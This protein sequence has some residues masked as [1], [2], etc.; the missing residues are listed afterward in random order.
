MAYISARKCVR[1]FLAAFM[2]IMAA[3]FL[4]SIDGKAA[5]QGDQA[6]S[7]RYGL[8]AESDSM[9]GVTLLANNAWKRVGNAYYNGSGSKINGA[10][11]KGIDVSSNNGSIDWAAVKADGVEFAI[12]RCGYGMNQTDQDDIRWE[13]NV[14][15]C[16]A[17]GMPY[18]V[19][20]YSYADS[21]SKAVSE[22]NHVLRLIKGHNLSLPVY[23]DMED[24]SI[25]NNT[26]AKQRGKIAAAFC[27]KIE[28]AGYD[29]AI[30]ANYNAFTNELPEETF[31]QW[32]RWVARYNSSCGYK[33]TY[34]MWQATNKGTVDGIQGFVD[35]DFRISSQIFVKPTIKVATSGKK[36]AKITWKPKKSG[37]TCQIYYSRKKNGKYK[38][39]SVNGKK[40]S[41]KVKKLKSGKK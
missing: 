33:G 16:E 40:G 23:F 28:A 18:G 20:I 17:V 34:Q 4:F 13:E 21:V 3:A 38:V 15:G 36:K 30:Y 24:S 9:N 26:T 6:D 39:L 27:K 8:S 12:I 5:K 41:A 35:I 29:V 2:I 22:A 14:S 32:G 31:D 25:F 1:T 19:Y 37:T 7:F 11:A 10:Y